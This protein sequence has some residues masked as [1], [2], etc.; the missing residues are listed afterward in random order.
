ME[1]DRANDISFPGPGASAGSDSFEGSNVSGYNSFSSFN[2]GSGS[3]DAPFLISTDAQLDQVRNHPDA[4]FMLINDIKL[5]QNT[6]WV[7]IGKA[8]NPFT[9]HFD[10]NGH[11]ISGLFINQGSSDDVGLFGVTENAF[12]ENLGLEQVTITGRTR[13]G[14][15]VGDKLGGTISN[16]FATGS[17]L[18]RDVVGGLV[19]DHSVGVISDCYAIVNVE[20]NDTVGGFIGSNGINSTALNCYAAGKVSGV[21]RV[22]GFAGAN[23]GVFLA[24]YFDLDA[25]GQNKG[26]GAG[27]E[28]GADGKTAAQMRMMETFRPNGW[29]FIFV[30]NIIP[31]VNNGYPF[32]RVFTRVFGNEV[33]S[34]RI[35]G[36]IASFINQE[37]NSICVFM[38]RGTNRSCL[39]PEIIINEGATIEPESGR[40]CNFRCPVTYTVT[41][42]DGSKRV[43]TVCVHTVREQKSPCCTCN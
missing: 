5:S 18:G 19:G 43:Y 16:C 9:G 8:G 1:K 13:V 4:Y 24:S 17:V 11:I 41:A 27:N 36:Q 25:T 38:P 15:L 2:G 35:P 23:N 20:G 31:T 14:S 28:R 32:L 42:Q 3:F 10:G 6:A 37:T 30:W 34:F 33:L 12:I 26:V 40:A 39:R 21:T 22:G 7:P 29:K